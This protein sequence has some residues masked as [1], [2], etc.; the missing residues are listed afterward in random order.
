MNSYAVNKHVNKYEFCMLVVP[1][2]QGLYTGYILFAIYTGAYS[3]VVCTCYRKIC[4][5]ECW[6][7][8]TITRR[9]LNT[10]NGSWSDVLTTD[11]VKS[12]GR[13]WGFGPGH[14]TQ[15]SV[16]VWKLHHI[17]RMVSPWQQD[18]ISKRMHFPNR[19]PQLKSKK[20][21]NGTRWCVSP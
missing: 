9:K 19:N 16:I 8:L 11:L 6:M 1:H 13:Q 20:I 18:W 3:N 17:Q 5:I 7:M 12:R 10:I 21:T 2:S 4:T 14:S 15:L